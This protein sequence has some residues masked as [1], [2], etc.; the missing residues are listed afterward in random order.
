[1]TSSHLAPHTLV[2]TNDFP[3]RDGGIQTFIY[4]LVKRFEPGS[5]TVLSSTYEGA[6]EFDAKLDFRVVRA[7]THTLLPT[8]E[9]RNL[10][11]QLVFETGA[12][13]VV[14]GAAAP[15][16]LLAKPLR[17]MGVTRIVGI[18]HGHEAGWAITPITRQV[19]RAIGDNVDQLTYLGDY[20]KSK[21]GGVLSET[22]RTHMRQLAPAVDPEVFH[23]RN[24]QAAA[25]LRSQFG[26]LDK[27]VIVCVSRLMERKG[28]DVLIKSMPTILERIPDAHLVIVGDGTYASRLHSIV[29]KYSMSNHITFAGK[30]PY[31]DLPAWYAIGDVFAMPCRTRNGGW[32]VEGLGIVFLEASATGLPVIAGDS[33]GAPDAVLHGQ[34][35]MVVDGTDI[36]SVAANIIDVLADP[37]KSELMGR[38]GREWVLQ[39]WTWDRAVTRLQMLL[40]GQ[41][42]DA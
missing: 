14:F 8:R 39:H 34:T 19:L 7:N 26:L 30:V 13:R 4:E 2:I 32:D 28:Q 23:P 20:T 3:P 22:A 37:E 27:K 16:G 24:Q 38:A 25:Q 1:M 41:D 42:P 35:G 36:P 11:R 29:E 6:S 9:T 40:A 17:K 5:V 12:T 18:T 31:A 21:I 10:A 33:G 15:L